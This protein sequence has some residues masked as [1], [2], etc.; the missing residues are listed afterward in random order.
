MEKILI[1]SN[2]SSTMLAMEKLIRSETIEGI[3]TCQTAKDARDYV[4]DNDFDLIIID[5]PL[6]DEFGDGLAIESAEKTTAGIL[7]MGEAKDIAI[8][9]RNIE[10]YG[11]V[12]LEKPV[13]PDIFLKF[14]KL[15]SAVHNRVLRLQNEN[16]K[17][18]KKIDEVRLVSR[19]KLILVQ[20]LNM[21]EDQAQHYIEKQS[22]DL[23][24]TLVLTAEN[25]LR[26]YEK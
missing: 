17:L 22:M 3:L 25:I 6:K 11:V 12:A 16:K 21:T 24:Q 18:N 4:S 19:A 23:R 1:V 14:A 5:A 8:R 9:C 2:T 13:S 26:T 7:L 20:V 10:D 15:L